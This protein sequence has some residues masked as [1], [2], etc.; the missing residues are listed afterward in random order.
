MMDKKNEGRFYRNKETGEL[1]T[2]HEMLEE[3]RSRYEG[4]NQDTGLYQYH[5]HTRYEYEGDKHGRG[6][7]NVRNTRRR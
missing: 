1:L 7:Y 4:I 3:W 6:E 2:Y 5:W